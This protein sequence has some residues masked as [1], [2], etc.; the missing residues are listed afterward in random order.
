M[1][2]MRILTYHVSLVMLRSEKL[3]IREKKSEKFER[4]NKKQNREP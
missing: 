4:A 2:Q 1:Y 3:E